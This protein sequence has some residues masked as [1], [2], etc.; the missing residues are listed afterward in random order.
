[1]T[2]WPTTWLTDEELADLERVRGVIAWH[3]MWN[4]HLRSLD[5]FIAWRQVSAEVRSSAE[6]IEYSAYLDRLWEADAYAA[7]PPV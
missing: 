7:G 3:E 6:F 1:M 2:A 4:A 5:E